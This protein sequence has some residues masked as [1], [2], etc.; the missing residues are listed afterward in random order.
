MEPQHRNAR[1]HSHFR[2]HLGRYRHR[3]GSPTL[4]EQLAQVENE[5]F[6]FVP[7]NRL[8][9]GLLERYFASARS[10]M[11]VGCG[12]GIRTFRNCRHKAG[13]RHR[14]GT[15]YSTGLAIARARLGRHA[16]FV[17]M[18]ARD[19]PARDVSTSLARS[20]CLSVS[21]T[22]RTSRSDVP[23]FSRRRW[24]FARRAGDHPVAVVGVG[25]VCPACSP[26]SPRRA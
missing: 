1:R 23:P 4:S 5:N 13:A 2:A 6:W 17:Q 7:R 22:I 24:R 12:G 19:I 3:N 18:D 21:T 11:E 9:T 10:F 15:A 16:E 14:F 20:T 8:I 25:R 26:L